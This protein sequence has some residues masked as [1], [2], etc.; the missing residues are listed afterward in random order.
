MKAVKD[1]AQAT[2]PAKVEG[3]QILCA[4]EAPHILS[5]SL[6]S[7][8]SQVLVRYLSDLG[9]YV[10]A[11]SACHKGAASHV[12]AALKLPKSVLDGVLR[13]SFDAATTPADID[14]LADA[15]NQAK[16]ALFTTLS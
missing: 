7:Y 16:S 8:K 2:L 12:Y 9:V 1:Y 3:L 15:L 13:I 14:T 6:P 11:G 10:S 5:F 4:T